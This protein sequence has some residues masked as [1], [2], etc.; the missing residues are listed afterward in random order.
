MDDRIVDVNDQQ[1][2]QGLIELGPVA[3]SRPKYLKLIRESIEFTDGKILIHSQKVTS[4]VQNKQQNLDELDY[5][6][7]KNDLVKIL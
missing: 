2:I 1:E 6:Q 5:D 4:D 3:Y 7:L